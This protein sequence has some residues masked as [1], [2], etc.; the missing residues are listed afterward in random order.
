VPRDV[1]DGQ[2]RT[3]AAVVEHID[4]VATVAELVRCAAIG[5]ADVE[6]RQAAHPR[7]VHT[8]DDAAHPL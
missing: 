2:R 4:H 3:A 5:S 7:T 6:T 1:D 8:L